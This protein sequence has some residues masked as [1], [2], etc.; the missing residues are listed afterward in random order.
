MTVTHI[1]LRMH[2]AYIYTQRPLML[3]IKYNGAT[4][5]RLSVGL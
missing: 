3:E 1:G 2:F 5:Y 4:T